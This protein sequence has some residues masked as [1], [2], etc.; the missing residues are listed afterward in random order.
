M[1]Q[2]RL[3][4]R[5]FLHPLMIAAIL[6]VLAS[7]GVADPFNHI[8]K[9]EQRRRINAMRNNPLRNVTV[10]KN[11]IYASID[12]LDLKLDLYVPKNAQTPMPLVVWIHGGG[13]SKGSKAN[14]PAIPML[15]D[16]FAIASINYR[17]TDVAVFPAQ[18][19]DCK[20]A[21][22][23]LRA[24]AGAYGIDPNSIGVWGASAGGHLAALLG[25]TNGNEEL[26]GTIGKHTP[27]S[28]DVQAVCDWFGPSDLLLASGTRHQFKDGNPVDALLGGKK[29]GWMQLAELASPVTHVTK[30]APPFLIMHGDQDTVVGLRQSQLLYDRL[31]A[32]GA[33]AKLIVIKGAGHGFGRSDK[34]AEP[35]ITFFQRT[36]KHSTPEKESQP[37]QQ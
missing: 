12:D 32:A 13:W 19:H 25:T 37:K 15:K 35:V 1:Q 2:N 9:R 20:A 23:Y 10:K 7:P 11:L 18:I 26:E 27:A 29:Q 14:C 36:L 31:K 34:A 16:G 5:T 28:S 33:D 17:L 3:L 21:I 30:D 24:N 22:R 6:S 8:Q 4:N